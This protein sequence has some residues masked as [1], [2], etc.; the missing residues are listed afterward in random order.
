MKRWVRL[1]RASLVIEL[2]ART[3]PQGSIMGGLSGV[4]PSLDTGQVKTWRGVRVRSE[5]EG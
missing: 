5:G 2:R 1:P 4:A 3:W